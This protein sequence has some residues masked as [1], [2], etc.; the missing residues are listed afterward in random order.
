MFLFHSAA[1]TLTADDVR[2]SERFLIFVLQ[3]EDCL[4]RGSVTRREA[5][6]S[7]LSG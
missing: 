7:N 1:Q 3:A 4:Q 6:D 5:E 2:T